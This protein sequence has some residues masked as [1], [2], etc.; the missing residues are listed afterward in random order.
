[1]T[2]N[3]KPMRLLYWTLTLAMLLCAWP[4]IVTAQTKV[5]VVDFQ[6]ALLDTADMMK[7]SQELEAK[8]E[9]RR[10]EIE[11]LA[12]ELQEIQ[13]K[14][15]GAS[16]TTAADLQAEG[17]RKQRTAQ[18]LTEDLQSDVEFDRQNILVAGSARMREIVQDLRI[19]KQL[20]LIIDGGSVLAHNALIDLTSDATT[21]Y[22]AKHPV[23]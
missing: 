22:D 3:S 7:Q 2:I 21:A 13:A 6:T 4:A 11:K 1:M 10:S 8:Y 15:Q 14:L 9:S 5:A 18:R 20:D 19:E 12:I 17:T 16:G 23:N